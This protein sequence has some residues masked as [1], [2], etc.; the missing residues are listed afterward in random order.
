MVKLCP[1]YPETNNVIH[2]V[3]SENIMSTYDLK[4]N[5][6]VLLLRLEE[7]KTS[8]LLGIIGS[9]SIIPMTSLDFLHCCISF[10]RVWLKSFLQLS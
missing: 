8:S 2:F 7:A 9:K 5:I 6:N 4:N 1:G 10:N 3:A